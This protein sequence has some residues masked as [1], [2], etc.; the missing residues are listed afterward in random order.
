MSHCLFTV[1][2]PTYNRERTL[3]LVYECLR[4]QTL[5]DFEWLIVDDGSTDGTAALV[6]RWQEERLLSVRY[7]VQQN[8]GKHVAH[9]LAVRAARGQFFLVLD[10]DDSCVPTALER[11]YHHWLSIPEADRTQYSGV[12][13]LCM[14]ANGKVIGSPFPSD[15]DG[16]PPVELW[17]RW[18]VH[19]EKWGFHRTDV[20]RNFLFPQFE[21]ERF[22]AE[23]LVWN[24]IAR[25][26]KLRYVNEALRIYTPASGGLNARAVELR[27]R[28]PRGACL[29]YQECL[30]L[31]VG[32]KNRIRQ[33]VNVL[34]F[35]LHGRMSIT[36]TI[37]KSRFPVLCL[38]LLPVAFAIFVV[39]RVRIGSP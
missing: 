15:A 13:C 39:D 4:A 8:A 32:L 16:V 3:P 26:F 11:F 1:F 36:A 22:I 38:T 5:T 6:K 31:T 9:N 30:E 23:G 28:N 21:G 2:T 7:L 33:A 25:Q 24:R 12:N 35:A 34:R 10:S 18:G 20:L 19:G 14:D 17:S 37:R 29:F 27:A